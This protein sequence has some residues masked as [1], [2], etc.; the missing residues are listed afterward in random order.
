[1]THVAL[2]RETKSR[3]VRGVIPIL[4]TEYADDGS[5]NLT[6]IEQ[7]IEWIYRVGVDGCAIAMASD[8]L[9]LTQA[10]RLGLIDIVAQLNAG[11]G[12]LVAS[13]S[14]QTTAESIEYGR[15]AERA[16][17]DA[18]MST[19][20]FSGGALDGHFRRLAEEIDLPLVVQDASAYVG[21]PMTLEF[22]AGLLKRY[23]PEKILYKP[24][25]APIGP[26]LSRLNEATGGAARIFDGN[27]GAY[28]IDSFRRGIA[29]VMPGCELLD[30]LVPLWRAL[31][32][33]DDEAAYN[34]HFPMVA[35]L[36]LQIQAG[37]DGFLSIERYIMKRRGIFSSDR[38]RS[39][40]AWMPDALTRAEID[41]LLGRLQAAVAAHNSATIRTS[42][43]SEKF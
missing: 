13:V 39:P 28:L 5:I 35:L 42:P 6:G 3:A 10:E 22:Q 25:V 2:E 23:G 32:Q 29:G 15:A 7:E 37:L 26:N 8:I 17:Y 27:G 34:L 21:E 12:A 31:Q 19:P 1:M 30:A 9:R 41:R 38:M 24:E 33:G 36:V 16:H 40:D 20:P 14:A 18:I 43:K 11:R 4:H